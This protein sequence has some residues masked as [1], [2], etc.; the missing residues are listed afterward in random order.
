MAN[1]INSLVPAARRDAFRSM[2]GKVLRTELYALDGTSRQENPYTIT[3]H[4]YGV[5]EESP[6]TANDPDRLRI[7]YPFFLSQRTTQWE[8]GVDPLTTFI[9]T[10][11]CTASGQTLDY[12]KYGLPVSQVSIAV[13]RGRIFQSQVPTG[14]ASPYLA[15]QPATTYAQRDESRYYIVDRTSSITTYEV[16]NDG[17]SALV[18]FAREIQAGSLAR[19][20]VSQNLS[21]YDGNAYEGLPF[22]QIDKFGALTRAESFAFDDQI[23]QAAYR[24]AIPPYLSPTSPPNWTNDYPQEFRNLLPAV[25]RYRYQ[26]AG[27]SIPYQTG[28]Y[29]STDRRKYDFQETPNQSARGVLEGKK[30]ALGNETTIA[31]DPPYQLFPVTVTDAVGLSTRA[32]YDYRVLQPKLVTD[33]NGNQTS[34]SFS[35]LAGC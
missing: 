11:N 23:L 1:S 4:V 30:D 6:P 17:S 29:R 14:S 33:A 2:R 19:S 13:P 9:F 8:R 35:P 32:D 3:E 22:G 15:T 25:A 12:D 5:R 34:Y 24:P 10:D 26:P 21:Y 27:G 18:D 7:F 20:V 31:Y 16:P 28:F